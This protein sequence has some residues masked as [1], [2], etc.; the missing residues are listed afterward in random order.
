MNIDKRISEI[1]I[2]LQEDNPLT[3]GVAL[4]RIKAIIKEVG[5]EV[6]MSW[7][8]VNYLY[9]VMEKIV[10]DLEGEVKVFEGEG[11]QMSESELAVTKPILEKLSK[12]KEILK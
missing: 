5:E 3:T 1:L 9:E 6:K 12:L 2:E 11:K 8:E 7:H 4:R 10:F